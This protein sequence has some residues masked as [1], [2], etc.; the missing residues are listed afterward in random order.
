MKQRYDVT[1]I[2]HMCYD[3]IIPFQGKAH[4]APGSAVLCGAMAA[5]RTGRKVAAVV[6]MAKAD[7]HIVQSMRDAGVDVFV[8]PAAETTFSRVIHP[9]ANVDEREMVLVRDA[10]FFSMGDLPGF[11]SDYVHLAGISNH[12]FNLEFIRGLK[13]SGVSLSTDMQSYVRQVDPQTRQICF[14]D[15]E[16]KREIVALLDKVKLDIVE[17]EL[18][19]GKTDLGAA[20]AIVQ[21]WG[22]PEVIITQSEGVLALVRGKEYYRKFSNKSIIGRTGRGD[23]T[24]AAYSCRR[25][26]HEPAEA[27]RFAAALVSLKMEKP[28]PF[29]GTLDDVLKRMQECHA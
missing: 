28:G 6:R 9:S 8:V 7:E 17:A 24:F 20:A 21:G 5:V 16:D 27:L 23:T 13:K 10:G 29:S 22:C 19:T 25:I 12:E 4:I 15:V 3:E 1:F 2:G 11:E 18:L 26:D 14:R